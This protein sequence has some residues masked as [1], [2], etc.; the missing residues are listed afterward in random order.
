MDV[1]G[2]ALEDVPSDATAA[3]AVAGDVDVDVDEMV[4]AIVAAEPN[5]PTLEPDDELEAGGDVVATIDVPKFFEAMEDLADG[6]DRTLGDARAIGATCVKLERLIA[7]VIGE[8]A[9]VLRTQRGFEVFPEADDV[10]RGKLGIVELEEAAPVVVCLRLECGSVFVKSSAA[11]VG[12][13]LRGLRPNAGIGAFVQAFWN[14]Q[15]AIDLG[16]ALQGDAGD[17]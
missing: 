14:E 11:T 7:L 9:E 17:E 3:V 4:T 12:A 2:V 6:L 16:R 1:E 8:D 5:G 10:A 15:Q 13:L